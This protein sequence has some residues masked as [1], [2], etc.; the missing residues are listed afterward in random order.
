LLEIADV[1]LPVDDR[2]FEAG[3]GGEVFDHFGGDGLA[4]VR[5]DERR[6]RKSSRRRHLRSLGASPNGARHGQPGM[7]CEAR[8]H[9]LR[10]TANETVAEIHDAT[11]M[12]EPG[13]FEH[14]TRGV[15]LAT[16]P[17]GCTSREGLP[18][19]MLRQIFQHVRAEH[20]F[21]LRIMW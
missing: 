16:M 20:E 3:D 9:L 18:S 19:A 8:R 2:E 15:G 1:G 17:S 10:S 11:L 6:R 13:V 4:E 5:C 21:A 12:A 14:Q 7:P